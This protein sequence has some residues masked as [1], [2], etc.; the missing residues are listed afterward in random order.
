[1]IAAMVRQFP[2]DYAVG[3]WVVGLVALLLFVAGALAAWGRG[4]GGRRG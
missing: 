1:M 4:G 2:E 3:L